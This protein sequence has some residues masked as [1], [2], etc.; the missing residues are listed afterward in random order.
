MLWKMEMEKFMDFNRSGIPPNFPFQPLS[1]AQRKTKVFLFPDFA[2]VSPKIFVKEL[3]YFLMP[4]HQ[5]CLSVSLIISA[6]YK[7]DSRWYL[8]F[9]LLYIVYFSFGQQK[10]RK[11]HPQYR[12]FQ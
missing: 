8:R 10:L 4:S 2:I 9:K 5:H 7:V 11:Y 6:F 12:K 3:S 1:C